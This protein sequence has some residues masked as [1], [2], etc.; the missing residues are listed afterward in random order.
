MYKLEDAKI[1]GI[2]G[3]AGKTSTA[4]LL[5]Q[6]LKSLG[7]KSILYCSSILSFT[8]FLVVYPIFNILGYN[9]SNE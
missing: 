4:Y 2:T 9:S 6:Y 7:K 3:T 5:H 8:F 1:I